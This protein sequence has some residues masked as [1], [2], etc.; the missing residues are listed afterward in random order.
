[1]EQRQYNNLDAYLWCDISAAIDCQM[2]RWF[3]TCDIQQ[4]RKLQM[5]HVKHLQNESEG[6]FGKGLKI[7]KSAGNSARLFALF[8]YGQLFAVGQGN[9]LIAAVDNDLF[10][11]VVANGAVSGDV[12][13]L[14]F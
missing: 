6:R 8:V 1:M 3:Y 4:A 13:G 9:D 5:F 11:G 2:D 10:H 12:G 7:E 14:V